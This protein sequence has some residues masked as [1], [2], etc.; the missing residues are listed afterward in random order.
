M[1]NCLFKNHFEILSQKRNYEKYI[2]VT[3]LIIYKQFNVIHRRW[4][5]RALTKYKIDLASYETSCYMC[6]L[7][8]QSRENEY[9]FIFLI[10][11]TAA[12]SIIVQK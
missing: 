5:T 9:F 4:L 6:I 11:F 2:K 7:K 1:Y 3:M 12:S 10:S 8:Y